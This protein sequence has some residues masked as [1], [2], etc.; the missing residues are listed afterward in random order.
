MPAPDTLR[1]GIDVGNT[2][3]DA[4]LI[5]G[6]GD[7]VAQVKVPAVADLGECVETAVAAL[8]AG[9][10]GAAGRVGAVTLGAARTTDAITTRTGLRRVAVL[11]IG[12]PLTSAVPPLVT[13]PPE[14]RAAVTA[15]TAVVAGGCEFDGIRIAPL[16]ERAVAAFARDVAT[17][18]E[19]VAITAVFS[20]VDPADEERAA[21]IVRAELGEIPISTSHEIGSMGLLERE[22]AT[23]LN[24]ALSGS[25]AAGAAVLREAVHRHGVDAECYLA[26]N[27]GTQMAL[28]YAT[29]FPVLQIGSGPATSMRGGAFSSGVTDAVVTDIGGSRAAVGRLVNGFPW[30]SLTSYTVRGVVTNFRLP[31]VI[32]VPI[33]GGP[34]RDALCAGGS[35][36]TLTDAAV[37]AGRTT[38]GTHPVPQRWHTALADRLAEADRLIAEAVDRVSLGAR[39][40]PLVVVGGAGGIAPEKIPGITEVIRPPHF[41]VANALGAAIAPV[42]GIAERICAGR[43]DLLRTAVDDLTTEAFRRAILAGADPGLL[44]VTGIE[45]VPLAYLRDPA[46]RIRVRAAGP[47]MTASPNSPRR[48]EAPG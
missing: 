1:M 6:G 12:A 33:G 8:L 20:P 16:D 19:A 40:L 10:P 4:V 42:G 39:D 31:D 14:L 43:P 32:D 21:A 17:R 25:V 27:D 18:A 28:D 2:N 48:T 34:V 41:E 30:E 37:A 26:Q 38:F 47:P 35:V 23:V 13:W 11:R 36:P 46:V 9:T 3:T 22:N 29:R 15:G 5:G 44:Q 24:A 45:E 7:V